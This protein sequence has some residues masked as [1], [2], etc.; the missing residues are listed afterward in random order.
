LLRPLITVHTTDPFRLA[1]WER[2]LSD[3]ARPRQH[4]EIVAITDTPLGCEI[5]LELAG[6][7]GQ[8]Q[9]PIVGTVPAPGDQ[10]CFSTLTDDYQPRGTFP[11]RDAT[12]WTHGGPP[13]PAARL[14]D[15]TNEAW[16]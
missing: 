7:M 10:V 15:E 8:G 16:S 1:A 4:A 6:G 5:V 9:T 13:Q 12:P 3:R 2:N 14:D 11:A